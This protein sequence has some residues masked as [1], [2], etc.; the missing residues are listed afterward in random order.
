MAGRYHRQRTGHGF[1]HGHRRPLSIVLRRGDGMLRKT[2]GGSQSLLYGIMRQNTGEV[3]MV[4]N[5]HRLRDP[6]ARLQ[7]RAIA[8]HHQPRLRH[9]RKGPLKGKQREVRSFLLD[10][11]AYGNDAGRG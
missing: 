7:Q 11:A 2:S 5:V 1:Q 3:D 6:S 8:D 4:L 9:F 10:E